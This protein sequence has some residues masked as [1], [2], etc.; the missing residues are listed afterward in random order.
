M[1]KQ[2]INWKPQPLPDLITSLHD[3]VCGQYRELE[4]TVVGLE[5]FEVCADYKLF[6]VPSSTWAQLPPEKRKRHCIM[7][8]C[9]PFNFN[10][11]IVES[12]DSTRHVIA[13][14]QNGGEKE[15]QIKR[16]RVARTMTIK[17]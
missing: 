15:G 3:V 11:K 9:K 12:T 13:P 6:V 14:G 10:S 5:E 7:R 1:L 16:K 4:R 8:H 17:K 2:A